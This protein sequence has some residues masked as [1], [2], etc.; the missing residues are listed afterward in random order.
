MF[1]IPAALT[2]AAG[3]VSAPATRDAV[4]IEQ[5]VEEAIRSNPGLLA[6]RLGIP[7]AEA[8]VITARLRPNSGVH[9]SPHH[10]DWLGTG[11]NDVNGA[12]PAENAERL[13]L[14]LGRRR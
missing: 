11:F 8:A 13:G 9:F 2:A 10:L 5:A 12:G 6:E 14:P 3:Q 1:A 4:T 7:V